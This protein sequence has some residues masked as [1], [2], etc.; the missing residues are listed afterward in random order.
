MFSQAC[1][2]NSV[3]YEGGVHPPLPRQTHPRQTPPL[4]PPPPHQMATAADWYACSLECISS[5]LKYYIDQL[6]GFL[7]PPYPRQVS[8]ESDN[9]W[10]TGQCESD[11]SYGSVYTCLIYCVLCFKSLRFRFQSRSAAQ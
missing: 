2:K 6:N 8:S 9:N 5:D 11:H 7:H 4:P 3:H 1:V 10:N